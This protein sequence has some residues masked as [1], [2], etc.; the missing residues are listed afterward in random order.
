MSTN[1]S[2]LPSETAATTIGHNDMPSQL[3]DTYNQETNNSP[4]N[5]TENSSP[6]SI[7]HGDRGTPSGKE[8]TD[9][10]QEKTLSDGTCDLLK[11]SH[12][13]LFHGMLL[14]YWISLSKFTL[15]RYWMSSRRSN[16]EINKHRN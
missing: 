16:Y 3:S 1:E 14:A 12:E 5:A 7:P 6:S 4:K 9:S 8:T 11:Q 2:L 10:L 15:N 13:E